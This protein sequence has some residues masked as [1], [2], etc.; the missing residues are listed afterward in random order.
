MD[1]FLNINSIINF[2]VVAKNIDADGGQET[3][4]VL[5]NNGLTNWN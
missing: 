2:D 3:I 4:K 1:L 5:V